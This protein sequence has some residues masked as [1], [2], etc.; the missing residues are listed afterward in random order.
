MFL[1]AAKGP[2]VE[3]IGSVV[4]VCFP[5]TPHPAI[6]PAPQRIYFLHAPSREKAVAS[7]YY[8]IFERKGIEVSSSLLPDQ[9]DPAIP[10][11]P[12]F[13]FDF[14]PFS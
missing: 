10:T 11:S 1:S 9:H 8:E 7:P 2:T 6:C 5:V 12:W 3:G 4:P 13:R 14:T